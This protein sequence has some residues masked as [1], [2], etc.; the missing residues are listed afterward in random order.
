MKRILVLLLIIG[1][2]PDVFLAEK[3][4][5]LQKEAGKI[6][7]AQALVNNFSDLN[8][9]I[10]KSRD[11]WN[12]LPE[13]MRKEYVK[14]AEAY[15]DY[16]WP[17]VK[18]TDYLEIIHSGDH[19]QE[20]YA[21]PRAAFSSL[22]EAANFSQKKDK[23]PLYKNSLIVYDNDDHRDAYTDEYLLALSSIGE[24]KLKGIITTYSPDEYPIFVEGRKQIMKYTRQ[25]GMKNLPKL[26]DGT[27]KKLTR[28]E[29]NRIEDT[30]PL[31][32]DGAEYIVKLALES[33][34]ERPL[35]II[36]G[37]QLTSVAD[38]YL[39]NPS[40]ADRVVVMGVFG[41]KDIT[42]N[43]SL[44]GW[45]WTIIMAKFRV[46]AISD[47]T[48]E[49]YNKVFKKAPE[50][51]KVKILSELDQ[52]I[53]LFKWMYEKKHPVNN[54]PAEHDYDGQPAILLTKPGYVTNWERLTFTGI[55]KNGYP[56]LGKKDNGKIWRAV[57]ADQKIATNEFW[58]VMYDL[59]KQLKE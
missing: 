5:L 49:N 40:I 30:K 47:G 3:R 57:D 37:G 39:L 36:T 32:I 2:S 43:A 58:R 24:I 11:F 14:E 20:A 45:A 53:P 33:S 26:F 19:R 4:D 21:A 51:P 9:P 7:L 16:D 12:K 23:L 34:P 27:N 56:V 8:F 29:S 59:Q 46:V 31:K 50:V 35:V 1:F 44:D 15:Q 52:N 18:A 38:A 17:A 25:S 10:Y 41:A 6:D 54:G 48:N 42:Y 13:N 22:M 28:P 55:D